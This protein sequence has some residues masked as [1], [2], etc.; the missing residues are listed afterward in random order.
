MIPKKTE[1]N[2]SKH[3]RKGLEK[4]GKCDAKLRRLLDRHIDILRTCPEAGKELTF[5]L[6]G[7]RSIKP[8]DSSYQNYR[9]LYT[10]KDDQ[11]MIH[12]VGH[13][14]NIYDDMARKI[15]SLRRRD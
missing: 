13:R 12:A 1:I 5:D 2:I 15:A 3:A 14:K 7:M 11:L 8:D 9:I 10:I 6:I 4:I